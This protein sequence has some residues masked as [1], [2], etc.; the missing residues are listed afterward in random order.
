MSFLLNTWYVAAFA[1]EVTGAEPLARTLLGRPVVL[2]RD[3]EGRARVLD[4]RC[5]HRFAPLSRGCVVDGALECP[6]HGLRFDGDGRCVHNPHG[7]GRVPSQAQVRA[8]PALERFGAI[9]FWPGDPGRADA[10]LLPAFPF[11]EP[12]TN[13]THHGYLKTCA[14]YQLSADNLLDLSH[15]QFLHPDT[16]GS[17]AI[18]RGDV[19]TSSAATTVWVRRSTFDETLQPFVAEGFGVP[20]GMRVD[21]WM[22]VQWVPPGLLTIVVGVTG[23]G[24]PREAGR[25]APSA[26]WLTPETGR[27]THYFFAFGLPDEMGDAGRELVR[28]AVDGLMKPFELEDLPMLEAQQR[29]LG[30]LDFWAAQPALLPIDQGAIR[31]R[32]IMERLLARE[33]DAREA[34]AIRLGSAVAA[35]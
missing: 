20:Q 33:R 34:R 32:R 21:R 24:M 16:L 27:T 7:D 25:I 29:N 13:L 17:E 30:E 6:Y 28:Y 9:W 15:F 4:D 14:H 12:R 3:G 26:H 10:A 5:A 11:V 8:Y 2:Y 22:D 23:A 1:H 19:E 35:A 18:A 31:A